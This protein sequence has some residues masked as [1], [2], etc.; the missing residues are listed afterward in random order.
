VAV[1]PALQAH[2]VPRRH[3]HAAD[4]GAGRG[5]VALPDQLARKY[6]NAPVEWGWQWV[7]PATRFYRDSTT[8][9]CG[10]TTCTSRSC[11]RR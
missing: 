2:L 1:R 6:P 8:Q 9:S 11:R 5:S 3:L 10:V 4:L 7:F